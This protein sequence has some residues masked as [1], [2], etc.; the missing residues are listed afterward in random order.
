ML[1]LM[2]GMRPR[3]KQAVLLVLDAFLLPLA[4]W[5]AYSLRLSDWEPSVEF[6]WLGVGLVVVSLPI[7]RCVGLYRAV[8]RHIKDHGFWLMARSAGFSG[9]VLGIVTFLPLGLVLPRSLFVIYTMVLFVLLSASRATAAMVLGGGV[10]RRGEAV[11]IYGA[12]EAGRQLASTLRIGPDYFPAVFLDRDPALQGRSIDGLNVLNPYRPDLGR[13][14]EG[15]GV[16]EILLALPGLERSQRRSILD[17]LEK[18]AFRVRTVPSMDDI[19]SGKARLDQLEE[20]SIDDLLGR[21]QVAPLPGLLA[22]CI[23]GRCV[24]VTGAGGSIGSE[25]CRQALQQGARRLVLLDHS[26]IALYEV[27]MELRQTLARGRQRMDVIATLGSVQ[28]AMLVNRL[29]AEHHID[30]VYHAAAYK[31]VP[32]VEE[33]PFEG[34]RNNVRGTWVVAEAARVHAVGHFVLISTDK[35]VRPTNVM[36]ASKRMAELVVQ[37]YALRGSETVFSMVRFGNVLGSS[38]SVVPLFRRQIA[39]GGPVTVTHAEVTRF[40]MTIPEAVQLVIQAGAMATGGEVFVLDMGEPV[41]IADLAAKMIHLS[42]RRV[43]SPEQPDGDIEVQVTGLRPGEKLYE[44]LLIGDAVGGTEHP[45][46]MRAQERSYSMDEFKPALEG[47]MH[48]VDGHS[49]I[50]LR[51]ILQRWVSGYQPAPLSSSSSRPPVAV[52]SEGG[53]SGAAHVVAAPVAE[54]RLNLS[55]DY[56]KA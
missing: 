37:A 19:L 34:V 11:A 52:C 26:E 22:R 5:V 56:A 36:G 43:K 28:D 16:R 30:T 25:L 13:I 53:A 49:T 47:I 7:F 6:G 54:R 21:E 10:R 45:R 1:T 40:F 42:G 31:H 32:I 48:A 29:F 12:G 2:V 23:A 51:T 18:L 39:E 24:L 35:A 3:T 41:R 8:T 15:M 50:M 44:E 14:L 55:P 17:R 9:L 4:L 33:N 20:V 27:E 38:G 46:V